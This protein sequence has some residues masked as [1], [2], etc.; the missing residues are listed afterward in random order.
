MSTWSGYKERR[1]VLKIPSKP[2]IAGLKSSQPPRKPPEN[3]D[4]SAGVAYYGYRYYDPVTGRWPSRDPIEERGGVNLYG[5]VRNN[6]IGR[7]DYLGLFQI[8]PD[9]DFDWPRNEEERRIE[10]FIRKNPEIVVLP[11]VVL[12][13]PIL[14][15]HDTGWLSGVMIDAF[16]VA[17]LSCLCSCIRSKSEACRSAISIFLEHGTAFSERVF[18]G[19]F[20]YGQN[21]TSAQGIALGNAIEFAK[22]LA[23]HCYKYIR[24]EGAIYEDEI[25]IL[26]SA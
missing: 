3:R 24:F 9:L 25:I 16:Y 10:D 8:N 13:P 18:G 19:G 1:N 17:D 2:A 23:P 11:P 7:W 21:P 12:P 26:P 20:G 14:W 6:G 4:F 5:F 15:P 22:E